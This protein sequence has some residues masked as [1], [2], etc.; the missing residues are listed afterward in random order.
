MMKVAVG[1]MTYNLE[2][3]IAEALDSVLR[4]KTDFEFHILIADDASTDHTKD[5]LT[6]YK[7]RYASKITLLLGKKNVGTALNMA[8][9]LKNI[10]NYEYFTFLDG[11]DLW[12]GTTRLQHQVDFLDSH[13]EYM[14]CSGQTQL[15]MNNIPDRN[16]LP[17]Q[18]LNTSYS[19]SDFFKTP[20]LFHTSGILLRNVVYNS[21]IPSYYFSVA[22]SWESD[23]IRGEDFRRLRHLEKGPLYVLPELVSYYRIHDKGIWSSSNS[24][25]RSI[26]SAISFNF[27]KKYY[28]GS[29]MDSEIWPYIEALAVQGYKSMWETLVNENYLYPECKLTARQI[30]MLTEL[31]KD[32]SAR[33]KLTSYFDDVQKR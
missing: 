14:L 25:E 7:N 27:Y 4:Q 30:H 26:L 9:L 8:R 19:F 22:N 24:A 12:A 18:L 17:D 1:I 2:K 29:L 3:Y 28:Q 13:K 20:I 33:K 16:I 23:A 11:D 31:L 6:Q 21:G 5:I 15:I 32:M 10:R